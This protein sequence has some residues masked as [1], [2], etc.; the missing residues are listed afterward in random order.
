MQFTVI[1]RIMGLLLMIFSCAMLPPMVAAFF[2]EQGAF[3]SFSLAY[4]ITLVSGFAL[5]F[6]VRRANKELRLRDGFV[7]VSLF[8]ALLALFG[9]LPFMMLGTTDSMVDAYFEAMSGLTTTGAT[10]LS[11][12][13]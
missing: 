12:L 9:A 2:Y 13:D 1:Q 5:W 3:E 6:P 10:V 8:W 7:I 11:G 4:A